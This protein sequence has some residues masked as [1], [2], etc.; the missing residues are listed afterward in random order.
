MKKFYKDRKEKSEV[1]K[2]NKIKKN[3]GERVGVCNKRDGRTSKRNPR[4]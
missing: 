1:E 3:R 4:F 2:Y